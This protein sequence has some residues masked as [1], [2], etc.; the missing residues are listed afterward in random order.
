MNRRDGYGVVR[1]DPDFAATRQVAVRISDRVSLRRQHRRAR[2]RHIVHE[3]RR[4]ESTLPE[5]DRNL[6]QVATDLRHRPRFVRV[7]LQLDPAAVGERLEAV[8]AGPSLPT[9]RWPLTLRWPLADAALYIRHMR[10]PL[11][12]LALLGVALVACRKSPAEMRTDV[13]GC[14]ATSTAA[15]AIARCLVE[16][17]GW[18]RAPAESAG[19]ARA[20]ELD[21]VA[22]VIGAITARADSQH[23]SEVHACH[24][25]LVDMKTCL[26]TRYGW[27]EDKAT[28]ADDSVWNGLADEHQR[29]IRSCLGRRGVGTGACLQLH[30]KWLPR[31]ALAL[32]D[33]IRKAHLP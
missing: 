6:T 22:A 9:A 24:E 18:S 19:I 11:R 20:R 13:E 28:A 26:I 4:L 5:R 16:R 1:G 32:D 30:Y 14:S 29:Q 17:T 8:G 23:A 3:R 15:V 21:S 31:R 10:F 25:V 12:A 33:S 27:E 7:V 2:D